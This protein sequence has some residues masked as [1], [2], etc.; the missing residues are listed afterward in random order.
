MKGF[1]DIAITNNYY[2]KTSKWKIDIAMVM[3]MPND[4]NLI[5]VSTSCIAD[6]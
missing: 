3:V 4:E 1:T 5:H 6:K 2:G